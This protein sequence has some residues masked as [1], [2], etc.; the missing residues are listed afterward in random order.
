LGFKAGTEEARRNA[1]NAASARWRNV[2]SELER[3]RQIKQ[4]KSLAQ[5]AVMARRKAQVSTEAA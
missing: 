4:K 1:S 2:R 3:K 5:K